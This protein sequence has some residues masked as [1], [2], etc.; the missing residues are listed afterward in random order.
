M[1]TI[2]KAGNVATGAQI[3]SDATGILE[4]R[5]GTGAGTT[6][7][8]VGTDQAVTFAAGTTINGI[9][10]GR[11]AGAI[12][13]NTAVGA[14]ALAA[15]TT[16]STVTA[17]GF[18]TARV[19]TTG[20]GLFAGYR[21]GYAN[22]TGYNLAAVGG[23]AL[24]SNTTGF[25]NTA[26]G[27]QA[28]FS[29][30]TGTNNT[31]IGLQAGYGLT[32]GSRNTFVGAYNGSNGSGRQITTGSANTILGGYDGNQGGLDIRTASNYIVL[33]DGDG[34]PRAYWDN[35]GTTW[36]P[37]L[38]GQTSV[39]AAN[40]LVG[41][42]GNL[43]RSTSALKYKQDVRDLEEIDINKFRPV[44]YKSKCESDDQTKDHFGVIA[45]EV[46]AAG[47]VELV[48]YGLDG[49]VEGFAYDRLT[50]VLLKELQRLKAEV[51]ALK[52]QA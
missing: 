22:T 51:A 15:N 21:A 17:I 44:R 31:L 29:N 27:Y 24:F 25:N 45:D 3:T 41:A 50:V 14:S 26:V 7:I 2:L 20:D 12:S 10:V 5:T 11:G 8:T 28:G 32:T 46:D 43:A 19:N 6:A 4:V 9:T 42:S 38:F 40:L 52:G 13:T 35:T 47:I 18:E 1:A 49:E 33:S 36:I 34:V 23:Q 16:G 48:T 37:A 30:T 39:A